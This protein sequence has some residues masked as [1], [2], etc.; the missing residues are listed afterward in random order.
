MSALRFSTVVHRGA[1]RIEGQDRVPFLQGLISNDVTRVSPTQAIYAALLT[2]QGRFLWDMFVTATGDALLLD[3]ERDRAAELMKKLALYK[4]RAKVVLQ[5]PGEGIEIVVAYG[6]GAAAALGLPATSGAARAI[7]DA[8]AY[9]DPRLPALGVRLI[10][11]DGHAAALLAAEGFAAAPFD[12]YESLRLALGVPDGS[13]D[14]PVDKALLL[15]NGFDEL[16]GVDW[17]KG[18]YMGQELTARTKYRA[19]IRK[20]LL[21]VTVEGPLPA[22]G[23]PVMLGDQEA[24]EMRSG[25][26]GH[27]LALLRLEA[28]DKAAAG[29]GALKAGDALLTPQIPDWLRRPEPAP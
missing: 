9:V 8:I 3:V 14:L 16:N 7:D 25:A 29:A 22:A 10:A 17:A 28:V 18:C 23:T 1:L 13:R 24:G 20:R 21:P 26:A 11:P 27:A 5:N 4:L 2:P 6:E 15:E 12:D 19:L